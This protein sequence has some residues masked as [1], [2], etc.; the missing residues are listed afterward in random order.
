MTI[1]RATLVFKYWEF[2]GGMTSV[3]SLFTS[4]S[5]ILVLSRSLK[6]SRFI[7]AQTENHS[8]GNKTA[9]FA[10]RG[11][12]RDWQMQTE[13]AKVCGREMETKEEASESDTSVI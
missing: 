13:K 12:E 6:H 1:L 10:R 4:S 3:L 11:K 7:A 5:L 8:A 9:T 2:F